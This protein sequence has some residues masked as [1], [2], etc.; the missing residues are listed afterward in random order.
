MQ[1]ALTIGTLGV[2]AAYLFGTRGLQKAYAFVSRKEDR[3]AQLAALMAERAGAKV[4]LVEA[5]LT[6]VQDQ[7]I[8]AMGRLLAAR[9]IFDQ[10]WFW[11]RVEAPQPPLKIADLSHQLG[12]EESRRA[13]ELQMKSTYKKQFNAVSAEHIA[14]V[15]RLAQQL[16]YPELLRRFYEIQAQ[17][18][19]ASW[20]T[21]LEREAY[22]PDESAREA[23]RN[24][25]RDTWA[26]RELHR[27]LEAA[28]GPRK[29]PK[30]L[31]ILAEYLPILPE[32]P[33]TLANQE[34]LPSQPAS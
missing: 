3:A 26:L 28:I 25:L 12:S 32:G 11:K 8:D 7:K 23:L 5:R 2:Y 33:V 24:S 22:F 19:P 6:K 10:D 4:R 27:E 17:W 16:A 13:T 9:L 31:P 34:R 1:I 14:R 20:E 15:Q 30:V 21:D 18:Q 29:H